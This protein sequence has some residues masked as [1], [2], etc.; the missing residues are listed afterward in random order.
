MTDLHLFSSSAVSLKVVVHFDE[1]NL[2]FH[3]VVRGGENGV[4]PD[5]RAFLLAWQIFHTWLP[6][7]WPF[8]QSKLRNIGI[9]THLQRKI[10]VRNPL[11]VDG[12]WALFFLVLLVDGKVRGWKS[13]IHITHFRVILS[14]LLR[15]MFW[16][17]INASIDLR[18]SISSSFRLEVHHW[19]SQRFLLAWRGKE[20]LETSIL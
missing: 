19:V 13:L 16:L 18:H 6:N 3:F 11:L 10:S 7:H 2:F 8:S 4:V 14:K 12:D 17:I 9:R 5:G 20:S 15:G 1:W